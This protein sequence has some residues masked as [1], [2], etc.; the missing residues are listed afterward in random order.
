MGLEGVK[1]LVNHLNGEE[2]PAYIPISAELVNT[3]NIKQYV[4][5]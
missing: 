4:A 5:N 3:T 2:V 1:L